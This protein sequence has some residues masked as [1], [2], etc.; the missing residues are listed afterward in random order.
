M[1]GPPDQSATPYSGPTQVLSLRY[2][3]R[4]VKVVRPTEPDRLLEEP[5]VLDW[6]Q[7]DDYM[8]YW[9]YLWPGAYLLAEAV[10]R[11]A[12]SRRVEALEI[13]C[14]LGLAGLVAMA[15]GVPVQFS[16]YDAT[17]LKFVELSVAAN[18]FHPA[19]YATRML[20]WRRLPDEKFSL[21]LGADVLYERRLVPLVVGLIERM[22]A[23]G[24]QA[25][26]AGPYRLATEDLPACLEKAALAWSRQ[27]V[28]A[29]T[30]RG[31]LVRGTLH[32]VWRKA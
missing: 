10:G 5:A 15:R 24:G 9:A 30:E 23:P 6:N 29:T 8:P 13:G 25:L 27:P 32:R 1:H 22:L 2:A 7:R 26:L 20:D 12:F 31:E 21:I 3:G 28:T 18:G 14:G 16:D 11:E 4:E 17:P 19:R